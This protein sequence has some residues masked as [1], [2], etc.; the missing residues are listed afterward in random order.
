MGQVTITIELWIEIINGRLVPLYV[1]RFYS[2]YQIS[3]CQKNILL[4]LHLGT[5]STTMHH[6][7]LCYVK[8]FLSN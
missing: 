5:G 7:F 2:P 8:S 6:M 1:T 3:S 4:F